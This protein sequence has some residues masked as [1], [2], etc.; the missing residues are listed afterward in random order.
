MKLV[1]DTSVWIDYFNGVTNAETGRLR[2]SVRAGDGLIP[3][4]IRYEVIRGMRH[5]RD[6][7][8]ASG[9]FGTLDSRTV[10]GDDA[11]EAA[12]L[13]YQSLRSKGITVRS[14]IDV[15]IASYCIDAALPL[16]FV[17]RDFRHFVTHF[18]LVAA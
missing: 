14:A 1:A 2:L 4:L 6:R 13:R 10:C 7:R 8:V 17:D 16:L 3:D 5:A 9:L 18:G 12:A 15:L 11:A